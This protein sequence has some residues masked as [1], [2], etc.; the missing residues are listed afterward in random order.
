VRTCCRVKDGRLNSRHD[1]ASILA[2]AHG[3][4]ARTARSCAAG[5]ARGRARVSGRLGA[6]AGLW[7]ERAPQEGA[8]AARTP[9]WRGR[10]AARAAARATRRGGALWRR[11]MSMCPC[12][13]GVSPDF[14]IKVHQVMNR[15]VVDLTSLYNFHK[16]SRVFF[17]TDF[18]GT[19]CQL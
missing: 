15:K 2:L 1:A 6:R 4:T 11:K 16:G 3:S 18:A 5:S 13:P 14:E 8:G 19:S 17:S 12:L 7:K 10:G 9:R